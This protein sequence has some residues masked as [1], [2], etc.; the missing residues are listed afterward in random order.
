MLIDLRVCFDTSCVR[1]NTCE[2]TITMDV[3]NTKLLRLCN[4]KYYFH[5]EYANKNVD[6]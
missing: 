3:C 2:W 6:I 1:Y 5:D 4:G